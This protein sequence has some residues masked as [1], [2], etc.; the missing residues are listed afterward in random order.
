[1]SGYVKA[2]KVKDQDKDNEK[3]MSFHIDHRL[4]VKCKTILTK[5]EDK[6]L[7]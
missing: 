6:I 3:L 5:I 2:F 1:M 7:N 4:S